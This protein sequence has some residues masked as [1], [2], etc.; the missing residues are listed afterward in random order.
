MP[1]EADDYHRLI[2][3]TQEAV[4]RRQHRG[5]RIG[6]MRVCALTLYLIYLL[7]D[8]QTRRGSHS[9]VAALHDAITSF[10]QQHNA[11]PTPFCLHSK[12]NG[13][14]QNRLGAGRETNSIFGFQRPTQATRATFRNSPIAM[15]TRIIS[16]AGLVSRL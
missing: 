14:R 11:D 1:G 2:C 10:I 7:T 9:S 6:R 15:V 13:L 8:R 5:P 16:P 4:V 3:F 12:L